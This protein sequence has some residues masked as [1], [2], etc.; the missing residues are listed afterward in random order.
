MSE[1]KT[2]HVKWQT[3]H[4]KVNVGS[5]FS[6]ANQKPINKL[7]KLAQIYCTSDQQAALLSD[8]A[9]EKR[10]RTEAISAIA[11]LRLRIQ[12]FAHPFCNCDVQSKPSSYEK[13]L[14]VQCNHIEACIKKIKAMT[15]KAKETHHAASLD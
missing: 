12:K 7:L 10:K 2:F 1:P 11:A 6:S 3:G 4:V 8:L 13:T 14:T 9:D 5:F 15:W